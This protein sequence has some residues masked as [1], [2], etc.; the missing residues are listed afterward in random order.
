MRDPGSCGRS[1]AIDGIRAS[2]F[3]ERL[4]DIDSL[5]PHVLGTRFKMDPKAFLKL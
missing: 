1:I 4:P 2:T 5:D 3:L